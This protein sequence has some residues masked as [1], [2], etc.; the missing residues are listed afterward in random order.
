[1]AGADWDDIS[2]VISSQYRVE[3]LRRL[4]K[5]PAT[6][7]KIADEAKLSVAHISRALQELREHELVDLLVSEEKKKGRV[8]GI[9]DSGEGVWEMIETE[10]MLSE[11]N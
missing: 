7:S 8:Y 3:T 4:A 6:P 1:M 9:T 5:G 2:F 11:D 10:N